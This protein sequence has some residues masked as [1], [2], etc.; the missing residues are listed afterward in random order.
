MNYYFFLDHPDKSLEP[1]I[2]LYNRAPMDIFFKEEKNLKYIYLFYVDNQ[3]WHNELFGSIEYNKSLTIKKSDLDKKL[4]NKTIFASMTSK[5]LNPNQQPFNDDTMKSIPAWRS[6]IKISSQYTSTSYQGEIPGSFLNLNL[7]LT[8][9]SPFLQ[10]D[11]NIENFFYLV[12]FHKNPIGQ[13]FELEI[14]DTSKKIIHSTFCVTNNI[15]IINLDFLTSMKN[16]NDHMYIFRSK[17]YGGIPLYF[18][19]T[20]NNK[21][22]SL[23]HT[24]PPQEYL[25]LGNRNL[26]QKKKKSYW[27]DG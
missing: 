5:K 24:H 18:S 19:R 9:C 6:N 7:S 4:R 13:K 17:E 16:S 8:S 21:S 26:Y 1:S 11:K 3:S 10:F 12:N 25:F 22:F 27:I 20:I 14:L 23:E 2:E 15:N